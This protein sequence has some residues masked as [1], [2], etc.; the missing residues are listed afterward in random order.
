MTEK[1]ER[2]F[3]K[4]GKWHTA[5]N[6]LRELV[7]DCGLQEEWKWM[8]PCYTFNNANVVLIH[9][10]KDYCAL[11]L[12]KGVLLNNSSGLLVQQ[13]DNVQ[14][15]RQL[16]FTS[17]EEIQRLAP[18]IKALIFEAIEVEKAG[19]KIEFKK[20]AEYHMPEELKL[21]L[22]ENTMLKAAFK[23]LTPGRQRG[24]ILH[25]SQA[26]QTKT[27]FARIEK[28]TPRIIEGKGL[29]D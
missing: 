25:I 6:A 9:G 2:F 5:Y 19:L 27:R 8:H 21:A 16:R 11:L 13:T 23:A 18:T 20:T 10:F 3:A 4:E 24:Y 1:I 14:N 17:A 7:L 29:T 26:K 15:G 22:D 28:H 12:F